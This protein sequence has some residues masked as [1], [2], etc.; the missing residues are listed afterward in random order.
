MRRLDGHRT[1]RNHRAARKIQREDELVSGLDLLSGIGIAVEDGEL[2]AS[3]QTGLKNARCNGVQRRDAV[4]RRLG[5]RY[6]QNTGEHH[7]AEEQ[8]AASDHLYRIL[9]QIILL[10]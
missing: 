9:S 6:P 3:G 10:S 2:R 4:V 5:Q 8:S 1:Q 7:R